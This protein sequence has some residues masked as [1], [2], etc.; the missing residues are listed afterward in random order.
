MHIHVKL[1]YNFWDF[2]K[3]LECTIFGVWTLL[4]SPVLRK[5]QDKKTAKKEKKNSRVR[6]RSENLEHVI[7]EVYLG[8]IIRTQCFKERKLSLELSKGQIPKERP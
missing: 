6:N 8:S 7:R 5:H 3:S 2:K 4:L 1:A